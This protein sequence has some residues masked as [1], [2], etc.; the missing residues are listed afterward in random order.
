MTQAVFF[1]IKRRNNAIL[2]LAPVVCDQLCFRLLGKLFSYGMSGVDFSV[3]LSRSFWWRSARL[4][5]HVSD[6]HIYI[7]AVLP[8]CTRY[9]SPKRAHDSAAA[10]TNR[11]AHTC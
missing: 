6:F 8:R 5:D 1:I 4:W 9:T 2:Q 10:I 7:D 3:K 11:Y